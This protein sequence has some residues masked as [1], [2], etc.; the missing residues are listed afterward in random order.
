MTKQISHRYLL[1]QHSQ[2]ADTTSLQVASKIAERLAVLSQQKQWILYTAQ[3]PRP[4]QEDLI[5]HKINCKKIVHLKPSNQLTEEEIV[6]KAIE[7]RT[8]SAI[9]AS[10]QLSPEAKSR[11]L[12]LAAQYSCEVFF[13]AETTSSHHVCH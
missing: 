10:S 5:K 1:V 12:S 9:V 3:C 11:I 7:A 13:L 8:S 4:I 2:K 6:V